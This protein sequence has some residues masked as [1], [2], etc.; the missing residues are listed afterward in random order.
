MRIAIACDHAG[1]QHKA[2]ICIKLEEL[3][4]VVEDFGTD[5]SLSCD[6]PDFGLP[7][8][9]AVAKG[10]AERGVLICGTG[11]GMSIAANKVPGIRC[12][13]VHSVDTATITA[14]HN[15]PHMIAL[16]AR[17]VNV[18]TAV[19]MVEAWLKTAFEGRH[20]ARLNKIIAYEKTHGPVPDLEHGHHGHHS[21]HQH[22]P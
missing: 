13:L 16:G 7:A 11:I 18:P 17:I 19:A 1:L 2:A 21:G 5:S 4:H 14:A 6:Y 8:A 12:A 20:Q 15:H 10:K 3:G 22:H 9:E